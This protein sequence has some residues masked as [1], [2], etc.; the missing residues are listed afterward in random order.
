MKKAAKRFSY[1]HDISEDDSS[2]G[3]RLQ[4]RPARDP[5]V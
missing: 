4:T 1:D 2:C 3:L 5:F